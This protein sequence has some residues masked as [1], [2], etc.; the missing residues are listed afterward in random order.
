MDGAAQVVAAVDSPYSLTTVL[1][2]VVGAFGWRWGGQILE[3]IRDNTRHTV[4]AK[5]IAVEAKT[6]AE[7]VATSIITNHGS[8]NIGDAIDRLTEWSLAQIEEQ[9]ATRGQIREI[10]TAFFANLVENERR[11]A[12]IEAQLEKKE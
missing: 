7:D 3:A 8:K 2:L 11:F 12:A 1:V 10:S 4:E 9:R 5:E 6:V